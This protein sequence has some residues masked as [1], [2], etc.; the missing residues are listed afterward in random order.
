MLLPSILGRDMFD[1]FD[2]FPFSDLGNFQSSG[3]MKTDVRE[4]ERNYELTIDVPVVNK[5]N[6]NAELKDGYLTVSAISGYSNEDKDSDG[7]Y[8]RRERHY[9][10]CSRSFYVGNAVTENE[11]KAN[12]ANGVLKLTVPKKENKQL[13]DSGHFIQIN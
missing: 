3:M 9:G 2:R 11:I 13:P 12:F 1:D 4:S 5:E 10:S 7:R 6:I 8:I